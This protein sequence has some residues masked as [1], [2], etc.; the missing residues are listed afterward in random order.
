[1]NVEDQAP[2]LLSGCVRVHCLS[3]GLSPIPPVSAY[4][5]LWSPAW[6]AAPDSAALLA[7]ALLTCVPRV[8]ARDGLL[9]ADGRGLEPVGLSAAITGLLQQQPETQ[10]IRI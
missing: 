7:P 3:P 5:C 9:W 6:Q 1:M 8:A 10:D 4:V 2:F